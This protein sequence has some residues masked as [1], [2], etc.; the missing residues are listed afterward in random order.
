MNRDNIRE[1]GEVVHEACYDYEPPLDFTM[2]VEYRDGSRKFRDYLDDEWDY[3]N[4]DAKLEAT[5]PDARTVFI[6]GISP[7]TSGYQETYK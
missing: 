3:A 5:N 7:L 4:I 1:D 2:V 6:T